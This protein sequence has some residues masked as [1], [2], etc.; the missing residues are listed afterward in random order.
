MKKNSIFV[1]LVL[2][3]FEPRK[4][5]L[6]LNRGVDLVFDWLNDLSDVLLEVVQ[7]CFVVLQ[8]DLHFQVFFHKLGHQLLEF[9]N[10]VFHFGE[11]RLCGR[12]RFEEL[13]QILRHTNIDR[14]AQLVCLLTFGDCLLDVVAV[15]V[16][17]LENTSINL[18][19]LSNEVDVSVA[20]SV[21]LVRF[22]ELSS[23]ANIFVGLLLTTKLIED[24]CSVTQVHWFF[25]GYQ[26]CLVDAMQCS[27]IVLLSSIEDCQ[28]VKYLRVVRSEVGCTGKR[29]QCLFNITNSFVAGSEVVEGLVTAW[30][31]LNNLQVRFDCFR[32]LSKVC[33][34]N[35]HA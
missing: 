22:E 16:N 13:L 3:I 28:V 21:R 1:D 17:L 24:D 4:L 32:V 33:K 18:Y 30:F 19:C 5:F 9:T 12:L 27:R 7:A 8:H 31:Q 20:Q 23:Q 29:F 11:L 2:L 26:H 10:F 14:C 25:I 35:P 6:H 34:G 15:L